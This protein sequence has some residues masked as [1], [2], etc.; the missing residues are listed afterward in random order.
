VP[1]LNRLIAEA[2]EEVRD[3]RL[4]IPIAAATRERR[5]AE[6]GALPTGAGHEL[7]ENKLGSGSDYTVFLNFL[8][9]PVA[10]LSFD[11]PYGVYHSV[12][13][14]HNWVS[15]IGDPGFRY[16]AA[17]VSLWGIAAL[18]LA[19]ADTLPIDPEAY[20]TRLRDFSAEL[21]RSHVSRAEPSVKKAL[22]EVNAAIAELETAGRSL[23]LR[24][25]RAL[26]TGSTSGIEGINTRLLGFERAFLSENGIPGRRWYRHLVYA[27]KFTYAPELFPGVA[28]AVEHRNW[29]QAA[30]QGQKL[31]DAIRRAAAVLRAE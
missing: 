29:K 11:G 14:N 16:H 24:R 30:E 1:S 31:A 3:P 25:D 26:D 23:N 5:A 17:L 12:Y 4:R 28:E 13:D 21:G 27:P 7:V 19:N 8:G 10:D 22:A 2:A 9:I 6:R 20:A 18:R 15:R